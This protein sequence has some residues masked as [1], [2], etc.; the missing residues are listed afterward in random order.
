MGGMGFEFKVKLGDDQTLKDLFDRLKE[1]DRFEN[2]HGAYSGTIGQKHDYKVMVPPNGLTSRDLY[3]IYQRIV[4]RGNSGFAQVEENLVETPSGN[5][6]LMLG[7]SEDGEKLAALV[8]E[9]HGAIKDF[10]TRPEVNDKWCDTCACIDLGDD[11]YVFL[12]WAS[13]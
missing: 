7:K 13:S 5:F 11:E 9:H 1:V 6:E 4:W 2:G 12:G 8:E 3:W 10:L